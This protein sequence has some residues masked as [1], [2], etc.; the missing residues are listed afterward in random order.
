MRFN[1]TETHD[2]VTKPM[3]IDLADVSRVEPMQ[4]GDAQTSLA[5]VLRDGTRL[6]L[7]GDEGDRFEAA[8]RSHLAA[9]DA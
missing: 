1:V 9:R 8:W 5:V 2:R 6:L 7:R 3:D 4:E